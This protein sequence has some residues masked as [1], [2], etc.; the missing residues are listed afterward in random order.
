MRIKGIAC[1]RAERM[2]FVCGIPKSD[3][4]RR[5]HAVARRQIQCRRRILGGGGSVR[6]GDDHAGHHRVLIEIL[7]RDA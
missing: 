5:I 1:G 4:Q 6:K 3:V 7:G 2:A